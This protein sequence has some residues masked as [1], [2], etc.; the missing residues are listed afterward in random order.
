MRSPLLDLIYNLINTD[1]GLDVNKNIC[2]MSSIL[3]RLNFFESA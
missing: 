2:S 3:M 1:I